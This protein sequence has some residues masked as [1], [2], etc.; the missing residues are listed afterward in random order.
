MKQLRAARRFADVMAGKMIAKPC[1]HCG[2]LKAQTVRDY[3][4]H[5]QRCHRR[6]RAGR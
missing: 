1:P 3:D 2:M 6:R 4:R 5:T